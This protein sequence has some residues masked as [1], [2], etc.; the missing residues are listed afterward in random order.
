ME[1]SCHYVIVKIK[2]RMERTPE[3]WL[4]TYKANASTETNS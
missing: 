2:L 4:R 1:N 3:Q